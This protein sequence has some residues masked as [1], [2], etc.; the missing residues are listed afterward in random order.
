MSPELLQQAA[1]SN[2]WLA[3]APEI[4][5]ALIAVLLLVLE[6]VLPKGQHG[7]IPGIAIVSQVAVLAGLIFN[8]Q[9]G[10]EGFTTFSGLLRHS[11]DGQFLRIFFVLA[12]IFTCL[13]ATIAL[14]RQK[15]PQVE[16]Y[17]LVLVVT[18]AMMVL[19]QSNHFVMLFVALET[20]TIGLYILVSYFRTS[21]LTLEAGL[22]F[23]ILGA[24]SSSILLFGIALLYGAAGNPDLPASTADGMNFDQLRTFLAANPD[25]L[26]ASAGVVLV[27]AGIAFKI[28]AVPFQIWVPDV[29]QGA[30][31]PA[32]AF[33][34][35][36][37]KAAGFAV[38]L[39]LTQRA[40]LPYSGL[41]IPILGAM[42][43]ATILF[44]NLAA[45]TQ[46]NVK[47]LVGLSGV[48]HAGYLLIGVIAAF[49]DPLAVGAIWFYLLAYLLASFAVFGVM[50]H[51]AGADDENQELDHYA[52]LARN[53]PFLAG[54]LA[55]GLGSLAGIPPLAGFM[56]KLLL[57][58][59]A[60]RAGLY[61]L[62]AV[63]LAGVVISIY[64]YFGWIRAAFFTVWRA[65]DEKGEAPREVTRVTPGVR[66]AL[67]VLA[68][69]S[70][71]LGFYQGALGQWIL[72]R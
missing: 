62:L 30:P 49:A 39:A 17:H 51:L 27:I 28:G 3:I 15:M 55:I 69:G 5:L 24:L 31:T 16:F 54:I 66:A 42:A 50:V 1:A 41:L 4:T 7:V 40:F 19:S 44:G 34:A 43:I 38:L 46:T 59:S 68:V 47:R 52:D 64:Y 33:L 72:A 8:F 53:R 21:A 35:V 60:Y 14:P 45:L 32:T 25:N 10:F 23:L 48:A 11:A 56:G 9:T 12:S 67:L 70:V 13:L 20:V 29:Y 61:G 18:A 6:M 57:F 36:S 2:Q 65:G 63:V 71:L 37:S 26:L 58:V 22:K